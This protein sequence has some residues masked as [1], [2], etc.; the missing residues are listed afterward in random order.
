[1]FP[2]GAKFATLLLPTRGLKALLVEEKAKTALVETRRVSRKE[3]ARNDV[4][5]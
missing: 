1:M 2:V 5:M 3:W 4:N